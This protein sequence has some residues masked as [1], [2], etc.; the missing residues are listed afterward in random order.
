MG[1]V[2]S[3]LGPLLEL[4]PTKI[5]LITPFIVN[6]IVFLIAYLKKDNSIVDIGWGLLFVIPNLLA[7][8]Q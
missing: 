1:L 3:L 2:A 4:S 8:L 7:L 5:G 6:T